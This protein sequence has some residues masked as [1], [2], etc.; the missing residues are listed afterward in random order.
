M[1]KNALRSIINRL[2]FDVVRLHQFPNGS[3]GL[4]QRELRRLRRAADFS[5]S[6][7]NILGP[8]LQLV[9]NHA[10]VY[11]FEEIIGREIYRFVSNIQAPVIL[12]CG[13]NIGV[14]AIYFKRLYPAARVT[15]FEPSRPV[16]QVLSRNIQTFG[17]NDVTLLER[18]VWNSET[19]LHFQEDKQSTGG[20]LIPVA[21]ESLGSVVRV[22]RLRDYMDQH[23]DLLKI[24]IEG[25]EAV[26]IPDI[27]DRLANVDN[28]FVE[29][30]SRL[31][32]PQTLAQI[33]GVLTRNGFRIYMETGPRLAAQPFVQR[34]THKGMDMLAN[35]F[36]TRM[37]GAVA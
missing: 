26:V 14:S 9:S 19:E 30:H 10:F 4:V 3:S 21:G 15:C 34:S 12:D 35:I 33:T 13:A 36:G 18:G 7:T 11:L 25:A 27:S 22:V 16:F 5:I 24:D 37:K 17:L 8:T 31:N 20:R 2:G 28:I 23:I 1:V 6:T 29:F 32:E